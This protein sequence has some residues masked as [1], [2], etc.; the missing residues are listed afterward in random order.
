MYHQ[1]K[2]EACSG[3]FVILYD[4]EALDSSLAGLHLVQA[5][6]QAYPDKYQER[7]GYKTLLGDDTVFARLADGSVTPEQV[8]EEWRPALEEFKKTRA[9]YLLY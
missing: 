3:V 4:R 1:F 2:D 5:F 8:I 7:G 9:K 6:A